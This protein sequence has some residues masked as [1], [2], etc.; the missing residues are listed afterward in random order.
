[1]MATGMDL[2]TAFSAVAA[3]L[4]TLGVG[5]GGVATGFGHIPDASKWLMCF[6]MLL[7]RLEIFTILVL[8]T[9]VF[10]RQ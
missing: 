1:M 8:F 10:W 9:P 4:N 2:I 5:I 6:A 3:S 7:G